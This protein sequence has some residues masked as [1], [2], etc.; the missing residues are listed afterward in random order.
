MLAA[1]AHAVPP[2]VP[3]VDPTVAVDFATRVGVVKHEV[4][5][6]AQGF[7]SGPGWDG[8]DGFD[9]ERANAH[10]RI[11]ADTL[12]SNNFF[13][14]VSS[15]QL[16]DGFDAYHAVSDLVRVPSSGQTQQQLRNAAF[17]IASKLNDAMGPGFADP[18]YP[19][20]RGADTGVARS[21]SSIPTAVNAPR[22][23][24][25]ASNQVDPIF[26]DLIGDANN[27]IANVIKGTPGV[28]IHGQLN[29]LADAAQVAVD[30]AR[31]SANV[32][33]DN[34]DTLRSA[35]DQLGSFI[36]DGWGRMNYETQQWDG[37]ATRA[38]VVDAATKASHMIS[39]VQDFSSRPAAVGD[40]R[41]R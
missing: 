32:G 5:L 29:L 38:E 14:D 26:H 33:Q 37:L 23:A 18:G 3:P 15:Q 21:E 40:S 20:P 35:V 39:I 41:P 6:A 36:K 17:A 30:G 24:D 1:V 10:L 27:Q 11:A 22:G 31:Y 34:L 28:S 8:P 16:E 12:R 13:D 7:H 2:V 19:R 4:E 9:I 25:A